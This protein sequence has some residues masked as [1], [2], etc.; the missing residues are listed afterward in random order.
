MIGL[1][2]NFQHCHHIGCSDIVATNLPAAN[3]TFNN[4][5]FIDVHN[6]QLNNNNNA[7]AKNNNTASSNVNGQPFVTHMKLI[8]LKTA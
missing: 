2:T 3:A 1:P 5:G 4:P 8:D 6:F 7:R